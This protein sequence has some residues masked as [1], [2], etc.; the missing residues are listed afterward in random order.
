M[1]DVNRKPNEASVS[2]T[3]TPLTPAAHQRPRLGQPTR[4]NRQIQSRIPPIVGEV[5]CKGAIQVDAV[6]TG[7]LG[8]SCGINVRQKSSGFFASEP[9]L[10]GEISFRDMIRVVGHIRGTV[11]SQTG[12]MIVDETAQVDAHVEVGV[13]VI[14][15]LVKGDI[16]AHERVEIGPNAKIYGNIWTRSIEIK[17]GAIF[18]GICSMIAE[19]RAA[20]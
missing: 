20:I 15:G 8:S 19:E 7:Q 18:E 4:E 13:A 9:E 16:V 17:N 5:H 2:R 14:S 1:L 3:V 10:V 11:Y 6:I 12:T